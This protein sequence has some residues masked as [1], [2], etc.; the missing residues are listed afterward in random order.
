MKKHVIDFL[1][2]IGFL[3]IMI[4]SCNKNKYEP[5]E[6][7][8][9]IIK[10]IEL[11]PSFIT[12]GTSYDFVD[13]DYINTSDLIILN[14]LFGHNETNITDILLFNSNYGQIDTLEL[15][16]PFLDTYMEPFNVVSSGALFDYEDGSSGI[17]KYTFSDESPNNNASA[18]QE[19]ELACLNTFYYILTNSEGQTSVYYARKKTVQT[20]FS[21]SNYYF[22]K[23]IPQ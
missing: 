20:E 8:M 1:I 13:D 2:G 16:D 3:I 6:N 15:Y 7:K 21:F 5:I 23:I 18:M 19:C 4:F 22:Y 10:K 12:G 17:L 14:S 9:K 11:S